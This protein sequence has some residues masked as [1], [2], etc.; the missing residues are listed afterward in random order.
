[1]PFLKKMFKPK[2]SR[3]YVPSERFSDDS[4]L[5][6]QVPAYGSL[7]NGTSG[8]NHSAPVNR[9]RSGSQHYASSQTQHY[10]RHGSTLR[11]SGREQYAQPEVQDQSWYQV[12][13][14]NY[15]NHNGSQVDYY[16]EDGDRRSDVYAPAAAVH[17]ISESSRVDSPVPTVY[18]QGEPSSSSRLYE[19]F[20]TSAGPPQ[21]AVT[22][23]DLHEDVAAEG[24]EGF[25]RQRN[26]STHSNP[27]SYHTSASHHSLPPAGLHRHSQRR[28]QH[29][30][31]QVC[32]SW[33]GRHLPYSV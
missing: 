23:V 3:S 13:H 10:P 33:S 28:P 30:A 20:A 32:L 19:Q 31:F 17:L 5:Y 15:H 18:R 16:S 26:I 22:R 29:H 27:L 14:P 11:S 9:S 2:R 8:F 21:S 25:D 6:D 12:E 4:E 7:P 1:M 24:Y